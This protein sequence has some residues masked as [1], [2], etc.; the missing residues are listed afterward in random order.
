MQHGIHDIKIINMLENLRP[1]S[2]DENR[3]K[4][5]YFDKQEFENW[6]SSKNI[7]I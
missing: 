3:I 5:D 1:L 7:I 2:K 6:L 4:N